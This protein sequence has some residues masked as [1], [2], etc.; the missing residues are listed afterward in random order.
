MAFPQA[1]QGTPT[2]DIPPGFPVFVAR[3]VPRAVT[4][5]VWS[6]FRYVAS[7]RLRRSDERVAISFIDQA[8][9]FFTAA[10]NPNLASR[11]LLYYYAFLNLAKAAL[12]IEGV[13]LPTTVTHG[14]SDPRVN[15]RQRVRFAGQIIRM[16]RQSHNRQQIFP[17]LGFA[18]RR[19]CNTFTGLR[20]PRSSI[21]SSGRTSHILSGVT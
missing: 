15:Q 20:R 11:P 16:E 18:T 2:P 21:A 8:F 13:Q 10:S 5:D 9:E 7:E 1:W 3:R 6:Y 14:I 12:L 4:S 17:E 19:R